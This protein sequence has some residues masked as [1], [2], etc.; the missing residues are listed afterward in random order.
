MMDDAGVAALLAKL[1][2][3]EAEMRRIGF[4][5]EPPPEGGADPMGGPDFEAWLQNTFVPSARARIAA[6]D[7]PAK[8][9]MG[10][11]CMRQYDYHS[12][13]EEALPLVSLMH[14]FD[15]LVDQA[16]DALRRTAKKSKQKPPARKR[17]GLS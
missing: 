10:V 9:M 14:E 4:W 7:L 16:N 15:A 8:S 11:L 1:D 3:I 12:T 13:V 6:R 17:R 5:R 2:A